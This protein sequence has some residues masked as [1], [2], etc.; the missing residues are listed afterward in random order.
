MGARLWAARLATE[1]ISVFE[2]RPG[3]IATDMTS[4][5]REKYDALIAQGLVP[6]AP[7][8]QPGDL[9]RAV[10]SLL[11]GDWVYATGSV[12]DIG[13]GMHIPRL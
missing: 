13:G 10:R 11:S 3:I 9:G 5:V 2:L 1:G 6:A 7:W 4:A 12:I 8:G